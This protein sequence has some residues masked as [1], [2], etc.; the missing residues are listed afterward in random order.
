MLLARRL[1]PSPFFFPLRPA[2]HGLPT[3]RPS[4]AICT[5]TPPISM[6]AFRFGTRT[7]PDDAYRF[8]RGEAI[9]HPAGFEVQLDTPLDFYA[10]TDHA[11]YLGALASFNEQDHPRHDEAI[12]L[13][14][15]G[16]RRLV[17]RCGDPA[18]GG[19]RTAFVQANHTPEQQRSVWAKIVAAA[20]RNNEPGSS[21]PSSA[22]STRP[23]VTAAICTATSSFAGAVPRRPLRRLDSLN[24]EDLWAG[25]TS[26]GRRH[27]SARHSAQL[28]RL[29]RLDV[30]RRNWDG[31]THRRRIRRA[32]MRNEPLVEV[33]QVKGTSETHPLPVAQ[34][35]MG[36]LRDLP[37]PGGTLGDE[38]SP[39]K[40][41]AGCLSHGLEIEARTGANPYGSVWWVH[42]IPITRSAVREEHFVGKVGKLDAIP[43]RRGSVPVDMETRFPHRPTGT[44]TGPTTAHP[45][46]TG[47]WAERE[48][49]GS[50]LRRS[51]EKG[52]FRDQWPPDPDPAVRR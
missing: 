29:R 1:L 41:C 6:D 30:R 38:P 8:A 17:R 33:T 10:V 13:G 5:S 24:P 46:L 28:Q 51:A 34:R 27:G 31:S 47:V 35:R 11:E 3:N 39:G 42:R 44:S 7:T 14:T 12:S 25:W 36:G 15:A 20:N 32:R 43:Q 52:D 19:R 50:H 18:A 40:L 9:V 26:S 45:G 2:V 49:P 4:S 21:P 16:K 37:V 22:T 48:H 23:S